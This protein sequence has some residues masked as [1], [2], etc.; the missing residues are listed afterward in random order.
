MGK[1][2][3]GDRHDTVRL[4]GHRQDKKTV[5]G[6]RERVKGSNKK[7]KQTFQKPQV[8]NLTLST[9]RTSH[10]MRSNGSI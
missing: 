5:A 2:S 1:V 8:A 7:E 9:V 4:H 3:R 10:S 6:K